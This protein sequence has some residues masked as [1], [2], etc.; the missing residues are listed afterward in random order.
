MNRR[1]AGLESTVIYQFARL[2]TLTTKYVFN[3]TLDI[4][5][6]I[7]ND[8]SVVRD[9]YTKSLVSLNGNFGRTNDILLPTR[10]LELHPF[11]EVGSGAIGSE[12]EYVKLGSDV[13]AYVPLSS[14]LNVT[15][16][17]SAARAEPFGRSS[18]ALA[19]ELGSLDSLKFENRFDAVFLEAGGASDVRGWSD[20]FLGAKTARPALRNDGTISG[21][22]YE[23][24]GGKA[25]WTASVTLQ[26]PFPWL[27]SQWRLASFIDAGGLS[28]IEVEAADGTTR[29]RD[30]GKF[31]LS[32]WRVGVGS[33]IR[34]ATP[35][36]FVRL[37]VG[38][39]VNPSKNDLRTPEQSFFGADDSN[40]KRRFRVHLSLSQRF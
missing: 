22:V 20:G 33:G 24:A 3:R 39:K 38:Y 9:P 26:Y 17:I 37:D 32:R 31:D 7:V 2:R 13:T 12:I 14:K 1:E 40:Y 28:S 8:A 11:F 5:Q 29:V 30:D 6:P 27:S 35:F 18:Q 10:G 4:T 19:G 16:R 34:Y 25:K 21:Y 23:P 15:A 36:G